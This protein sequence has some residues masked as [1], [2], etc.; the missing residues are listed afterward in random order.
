MEGRF[1]AN[2]G[3]NKDQS[4]FGGASTSEGLLLAAERQRWWAL[5]CVIHACL[6]FFL[7]ASPSFVGHHFGR[8]RTVSLLW[9]D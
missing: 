6:P 1:G 2:K 7:L 4:S 9:A 3:E 5:H 8:H